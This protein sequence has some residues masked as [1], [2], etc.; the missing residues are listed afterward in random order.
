LLS[1]GA[2]AVVVTRDRADAREPSVDLVCIDLQPSRY[3]GIRLGDPFGV[4]GK[5]TL[6]FVP[7]LGNGIRWHVVGARGCIC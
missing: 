5:A 6:R 1:D 4:P 3:L 7:D 2:S